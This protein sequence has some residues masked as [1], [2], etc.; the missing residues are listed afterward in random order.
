[1]AIELPPPVPGDPGAMRALAARL[2]G[3]A[4]SAADAAGSVHAIVTGLDFRGPAASRLHGVIGGW[5]GRSR[6]A[7]AELQDL[8]DLLLRSA[9]E[10]EAAQAER[11]RLE[12]LLAE[13]AALAARARH[14]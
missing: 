9:A 13:E 1:M 8:S 4:E 7:A 10:V 14:G 2:R 6:R 12:R 11:A 5:S 3:I